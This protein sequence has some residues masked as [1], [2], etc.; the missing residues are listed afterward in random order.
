MVSFSRF[1][2]YKGPFFEE[3]GMVRKGPYF[4]EH[5]MISFSRF[6]LRTGPYTKEN[7][8]NAHVRMLI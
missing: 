5:E 8:T 7:E 1:P 6:P 3:Y 2:L 4:E